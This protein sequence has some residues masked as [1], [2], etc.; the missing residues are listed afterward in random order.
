MVGITPGLLLRI[1]T[2][3]DSETRA[4]R[5][6]LRVIEERARSAGG[7]KAV[8]ALNERLM[9]NYSLIRNNGL[10]QH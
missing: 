9:A 5:A 7:E 1:K 3:T 4:L 2:M 6:A 8:Q 10:K